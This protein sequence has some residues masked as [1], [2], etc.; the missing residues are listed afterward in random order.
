MKLSNFLLLSAVVLAPA[1]VTLSPSEALAQG[2]PVDPVMI[3]HRKE[4][5]HTYLLNIY[6]NQKRKPEAMAQYK[7]LLGMKP[8]DPK[9][10]NDLGK[11]EASSGQMAAA[12]THMKKACDLDPGN[13][14]FWGTLGQV[15]IKNKQYTPAIEAYKRAVSLGGADYQKPY[16]EAFKYIEYQKRQDA[17][18]KQKK[19]YDAKAAAAKKAG[20]KVE[21]DDDW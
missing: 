14:Q 5:I 16:E 19:D 8:N 9:L 4:S 2:E 21:D 17:Y 18:V 6:I 1:V 20:G 13:A 10:N 11:F 3:A 12:I 7:I 15:Y